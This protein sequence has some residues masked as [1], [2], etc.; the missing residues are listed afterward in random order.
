[1]VPVRVRG[2]Q[3]DDRELR[4]GRQRAERVEIRKASPPPRTSVAEVA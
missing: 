1:M 3:P 4:L 2:Q